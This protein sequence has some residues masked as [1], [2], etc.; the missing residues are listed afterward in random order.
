MK[1][2]SKMGLIV[3]VLLIMVGSFLLLSRE[4][5]LPP[6]TLI[7]Q[8][9][10]D[11]EKGAK[12]HSA[13]RVMDVISEDFHAGM[14]NRKQLYLQVV[15]SMRNGR[16][17]DYDAHVTEPRILPSPKGNPNERLVFTRL[18]VFENGSGQDIWGSGMLT[19]VMRK[20]YRP[21]LL[22]FRE[23]YWRIVSVAN[24]PP[25]AEAGFDGI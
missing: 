13:R 3:A 5:N 1:P 25:F 8:S 17:T 20:E 24:I 15:Q 16:G 11:A 4:P 9:L 10:R 6:E 2:S 22:V 21:R 12:N 14:W 19:L 23:P 18:S 7:Q